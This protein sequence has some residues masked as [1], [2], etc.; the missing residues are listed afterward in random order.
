MA[1]PKHNMFLRG[2]Y[3]IGV[4][5]MFIFMSM[6]I[7]GY[8]SEGTADYKTEIRAGYDSL[9]SSQMTDYDASKQ[10]TESK[11]VKLL[12]LVERPAFKVLTKSYIL[13]LNQPI[14]DQISKFWLLLFDDEV[15]LSSNGILTDKTVYQIYRNYEPMKN[16]VEVLLGFKVSESMSDFEYE[17]LILEA[18]SMLPRRSVLDSW[19]NHEQLPIKL[20]YELD[21]EIFQLDDR[22]QVISQKAFL[23]SRGSNRYE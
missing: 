18:S 2:L 16:T 6:V 8:W 15:M 19:Q 21:Y 12:G 1:L 11:P 20:S 17:T 10:E 3:I 14:H 13:D 5:G 23:N 4:I 9:T 7:R 22:F